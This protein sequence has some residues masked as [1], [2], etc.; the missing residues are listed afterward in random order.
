MEVYLDH[1]LQLIYPYFSF[2]CTGSG[3]SNFIVMRVAVFEG[4]EAGHLQSKVGRG[5]SILFGSL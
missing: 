2:T 3:I 5:W 4:L 1:F